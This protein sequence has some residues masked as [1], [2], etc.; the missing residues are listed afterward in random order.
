MLFLL[1]D[2]WKLKLAYMIT[3]RFDDGNSPDIHDKKPK[4]TTKTTQQRKGY[5]FFVSHILD[6][7][8]AVSY[9][10]DL[11]SSKFS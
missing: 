6:P 4:T 9:L 10:V 8:L 7:I 2:G 3:A 11:V 5:R 1:V